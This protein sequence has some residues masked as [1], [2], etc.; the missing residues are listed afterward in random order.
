MHQ[1]I[2]RSLLLL[3]AA[4]AITFAVFKTM[5]NSHA[6]SSPTIAYQPELAKDD[7]ANGNP[8]LARWEGPFGGVPPFDR[9]KVAFFKPA[10]EAAMA[11]QLGEID[12]VAKNTAAPTFENTIVALEEAG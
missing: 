3:F 2:T 11:E 5:D 6:A 9:V 12:R 10:L 8:L 1:T 7:T 4:A